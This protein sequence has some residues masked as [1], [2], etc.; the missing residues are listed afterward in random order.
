MIMEEKYIYIK[1]GLGYVE[2]DTPIST[3]LNGN[4][5]GSTWEDYNNG[6]FVLLSAEQLAFKDE[7]PTAS[8]KEVF[9]MEITPTPVRT[10]E[11]AK[12][13]MIATIEEYDDSNSVNE[14]IVTHDG[15]VVTTDW[16]EPNIRANYKNSVESAEL[17]GLPTVSFYVGD[18][19]I[20]LPTQDAKLMLAQ[21]QL[22]ADACYIVT[23]QHIAAVEALTTIEAVDAFD[24]TADYPNKLSFEV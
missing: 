9:D 3:E 21:I 10:L 5:L 7:H 23:R 2:F 15:Q 22:Y 8:I 12:N 4:D 14:F 24:Y 6:K 1:R 17:V 16:F 13:E 11:D 18:M 19:P 20:T